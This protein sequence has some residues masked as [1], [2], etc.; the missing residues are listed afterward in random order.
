MVLPE[1][2]HRLPEILLRLAPEDLERF[3][4]EARA[5]LEESAGGRA[6][7]PSTQRTVRRTCMRVAVEAKRGQIVARRVAGVRA[8]VVGVFVPSFMT[9]QS[10][11]RA[12]PSGVPCQRYGRTEITHP[13]VLR[14]VVWPAPGRLPGALTARRTAPVRW[15]TSTAPVAHSPEPPYVSDPALAGHSHRRPTPDHPSG[16][17]HHFTPAPDPHRAGRPLP[18]PRPWI[19]P[20]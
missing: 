17:V 4:L 14:Q 16:F 11:G 7:A 8:R 20:N 9:P 19:S 1:V 15:P 18:E 10:R 5:L 13:G 2:A 12:V 3:P 6:R